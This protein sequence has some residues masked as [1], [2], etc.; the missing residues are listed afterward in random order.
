MPL[1]GAVTMRYVAGA[2]IVVRGPVTRREYRF[3]RVEPLQQVART[4]V[5]PLLATGYFMRET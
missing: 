1:A 2:P 5:E 3:S 4:D